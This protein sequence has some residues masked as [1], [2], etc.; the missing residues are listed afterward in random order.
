MRYVVKKKPLSGT[1]IGYVVQKEIKIRNI[2][3]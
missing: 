3:Y 2:I 1:S